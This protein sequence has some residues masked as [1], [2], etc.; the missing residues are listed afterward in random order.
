MNLIPI[1]ILTHDRLDH[2][3]QSIESLLLNDCSEFQ[4]VYIFLDAPCSDKYI[5]KNK[6]II[7]YVNSLKG[8]NNLTLINHQLNIGSHNNFEFAVN[9]IFEKYDKLIFLEDDIIVSKNFISYMN[10]AMC[11]FESDLKCISVSGFTYNL[12]NVHLDVYKSNYLFAWGMGLYKEKY[13]SHTK[14]FNRWK[15]TLLNPFY[16]FKLITKYPFILNS[17][18]AQ[19]YN[20]KKWYD[21]TITFYM[22]NHGLYSILPTKTLVKNIGLDGSGENC[23]A[24]EKLQ[25]EIVF[26][27]T[28]KKIFN[29]E[30]SDIKDKSLHKKLNKNFKITNY[31]LLRSFFLLFII[32]FKNQKTNNVNNIKHS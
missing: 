9:Y 14:A 21:T 32:S 15:K 17:M 16:L 6:Q 12:P 28:D 29:F 13:I 7:D 19:E 31:R 3:K 22:I 8:F 30:T 25:S 2:L 27:N 18:I 26:N 10:Q 1:V 23:V 20:K 11:Y 24:N 4:N 5:L